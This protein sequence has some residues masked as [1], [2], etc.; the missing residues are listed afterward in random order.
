MRG[1]YATYR[2]IVK[3]PNPRDDRGNYTTRTDMWLIN[4]GI[5]FGFELYK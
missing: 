3:D 1:G 5:K 2:N 4:V